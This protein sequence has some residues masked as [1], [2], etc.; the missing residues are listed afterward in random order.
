MWTQLPESWRVGKV[1]HLATV[2]LGKMLQSANSGRDVLANYLRAANVQPDGVLRLDDVKTMFFSARELGALDLNQ[3][4]VVVVEGGIGGYGRAAFIAESLHG[5]GFQNSIN[6]LRPTGGADGRYIA[7][8]LIALRASGFIEAYCN[9]V[10]MPHLTAEK[11]SAAPIPLPP[12]PMQRA[13]AD[14]LD[15]E[16]AR[17]DTLIAKQE[18]LIA[19]L[20]E[21]RHALT[22]RTVS[23]GLAHVPM[24]PS[25]MSWAPEVPAHWTVANIR[26]FADMRTGHTPSRSVPEY[27]EDVTI[28]WS[29]LADVWQIRDGQRTYLGETAS[30]ISDLG[31]ANSAADLLPAG[32]V[33]LSRT[34][35][36]GF[37]GIMPIPMTT[38]QDYWNW[39]CGPRLLPE[40]LVYAFRAMRD[41]LLGLMLGSTHQ[42]IYQPVA[43]AIMIPVPPVEEQETIVRHLDAQIS[44]I[45]SLIAK[46]ER[47]IGLSKERRSA[48]A[49]A[50]SSSETAWVI[51][52]GMP[53]VECLDCT[54]RHGFR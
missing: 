44:K 45:D 19:T 13:I 18:Q 21:R 15:R 53:R 28:P 34:A 40:Y 23:R 7:H 3:G 31:L 48:R 54:G 10:S 4:D 35:S 2:T 17:I 6:R 52:V 50:F 46:A 37:A 16:T 51:R 39:I 22:V 36:I 8:Y 38:S 26:R 24:K 5:W 20:R 14:F 41:A 12:N 27:W 32:T 25:P 47:F 9:I 29:T 30:R 49:R 42:T 43:S 33:V 11:L 1:K